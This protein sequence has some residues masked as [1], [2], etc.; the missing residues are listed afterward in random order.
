MSISYEESRQIVVEAELRR[1]S[2]EDLLL[3]LRRR[4][5]FARIQYSC[6]IPRH[7]TKAEG[8]NAPDDYVFQRMFSELGRELASKYLGGELPLP[9]M[10]RERENETHFTYL[11]K[12]TIPMNIVV[13]KK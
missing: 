5:R 11:E 8:V 6:V 3:E 13:E 7:I 2:D 4:K 9:G 1:F 10:K 12:F